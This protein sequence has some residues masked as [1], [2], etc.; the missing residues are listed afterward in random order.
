MLVFGFHSVTARLRQSTGAFGELY[1]DARRDVVIVDGPLDALDHAAPMSCYGG[2]MGID[3]TKKGPEEGHTRGW[4]DALTMDPA[5][6]ARIDAL[7]G[8][9]GL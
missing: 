1:V 4:P 6:K 5:T 7:W 9:L 2:K 3:A 8:E